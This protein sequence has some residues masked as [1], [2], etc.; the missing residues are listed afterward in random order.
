MSHRPERVADLVRRE[1]ADILRNEVRDPRV[2]LA[3]VSS[4]DL[5][6]DLH[7][8]KV[9]VS[10]LGSDAEREASLEA[11]QG[12]SGFIRRQL[13]RRLTLRTVPELVFQLDRG[14]EYSQRISDLLEEIDR[15]RSSS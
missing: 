8:A 14:A 11:I 7:H 10:V 3:T 9:K 6:G 13:G 4:V 2:G 1:L 12:A 5:S 15:E